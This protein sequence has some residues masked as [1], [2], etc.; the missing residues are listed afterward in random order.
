LT[1]KTGSGKTAAAILPVITNNES[2]IFVYPTNALIEDQ[3]RS[4][5]SLLRQE[6][7]SVRALSPDNIRAKLGSEDYH[8]IRIDARRLEEFRVAL[9]VRDRGSALLRLIQP[10]RPKILLINPDLLYLI[11]SLKYG[12][13][14][15]E[16]IA[17]VEAYQTV[18]FDEFHLYSGVELAHSLFLIHLVRQ[19][20]GFSR[21]VLLSA[22]PEP[23]VL[24]LLN[25]LLR[26]PPLINSMVETKRVSIGERTA[27][28]LLTFECLS[29][30][31]DEVQA[32]FAYLQKN[33]SKLEAAREANSDE[34]YVPAVVILNS[35]V[36]AMRLE[37]MLLA[38]GWDRKQIGVVRGLMA[39]HER[40]IQGR[41]GI[42]GTSAIE[43]GVDF[44]ADLLLFE[45]GDAASFLQRIGRV[46]RH[47]AGKAVLLS[48]SREDVAFGCLPSELSREEFEGM[49]KRVYNERDAFAWFPGT[50]GGVTTMIAQAE[51]IRRR[52]ED[53]K[54]SNEE[55]KTAVN[56]WL[57]SA[58]SEFGALMGWEKQVTRVRQLIKQAF[59]GGVIGSWVK[60]YVSEVSFRSSI[61][62]VS[63]YDWAEARRGRS[64]EYE[65][66]LVSLLRWGNQ[67]P[68]YKKETNTIYIDGFQRESPHRIHLSGSFDD[69]EIGIIYT[70]QDYCQS[71][72]ILRDNHLTSISH[73][74]AMRPHIFV[75][76]SLDFARRLDWRLPWFRCGSQ[77]NKSA[78][79]DGA[80]LV[81][82][83]L[84]KQYQA[85]KWSL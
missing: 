50:F 61:P 3:E 74:F 77:G 62:T 22:T 69:E 32:C 55:M 38:A 13:A 27:A 8:L 25:R 9:R 54:K 4:I 57:D 40:Q 5:L 60:A 10:S 47:G 72:K 84:W 41:V 28:F 42:I 64:P 23:E 12:R 37:D 14:S 36:S 59:K 35:V 56:N 24:T 66:D 81:A 17:H 26:N 7:V 1:T 34:E 31:S 51:S 83:E 63:I 49:V 85:G 16:L 15:A 20:G 58:I 45:A 39:R 68:R 30:G 6:R 78:V 76:L 19:F 65:A 67:S 75:L 48:N 73:I 71:L 21:V 18:V 33:K 43:V 80:A 29:A 52:V 53:D 79:F 70:T 44:N 11:F 46:G 82:W 2:A